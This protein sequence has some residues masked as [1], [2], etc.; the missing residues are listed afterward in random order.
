MCLWSVIKSLTLP[1]SRFQRARLGLL[2]PEVK[3]QPCRGWT[4]D[5]LS[6]RHPRPRASGRNTPCFPQQQ[7]FLREPGWLGQSRGAPFSPVLSKRDGPAP[8]PGKL[9]L[10]P[11]GWTGGT[12]SQPGGTAPP[13]PAE[14]AQCGMYPA[15]SSRESCTSPFPPAVSQEGAGEPSAKAGPKGH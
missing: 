3:A 1:L 12:G 5:A 14:R 13:S 7:K 8:Q 9:L 6:P 10:P 4:G 11:P 2:A 15:S